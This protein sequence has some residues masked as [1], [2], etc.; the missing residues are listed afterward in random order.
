MI[1]INNSADYSGLGIGKAPI[2]TEKT[3]E[4]LV[5]F[6]S[7]TK[8][9]MVAFQNFMTAIGDTD[10]TIWGELDRI[11]FPVLAHGVL[12][13]S[14]FEL[15]SGN[16]VYPNTSVNDSNVANTWEVTTNGVKILSSQTNPA[17]AV[18]SIEKGYDDAML[19]ALSEP[20][21][22]GS[23]YLLN[24]GD[25]GTNSAGSIMKITSSGAFYFNNTLAKDILALINFKQTTAYSFGS[26]DDISEKVN[27]SYSPATGTRVVAIGCAQV[28]SQK[29]T[30]GIKVYG[31][32]DGLSVENA[33]ILGNAIVTFNN[34]MAS[35]S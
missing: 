29:W 5:G 3:K 32:G 19:F 35:L 2:I 24:F 25:V 7:V 30:S 21:S 1:F 16:I 23:K 33:R 12:K 18:T 15:K 26:V 22:A 8:D 9:E 11:Y 10:G 4:L 17:G 27:E 6:P 13:D 20:L 14:F 34:A 31:F 28:F